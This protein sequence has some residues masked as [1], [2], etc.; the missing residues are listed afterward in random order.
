YGYVPEESVAII[1][2]TLYSIST[3]LHIGQA[4]YFRIWWLFPTAVACGVG[5]IIGWSGRLW[6][7]QNPYAYTPFL[8][9]ISTTV[10]APSL[11]LAATFIIMSRI[12]AQLGTS[13][14]WLTPKWCKC[15]D[16]IALVVQAVGGGI[17]SAATDLAGANKGAN[18]MLGGIAFQFEVI[19][20]FTIL[21]V[22][23]VQR[24]IRDRPVRKAGSR[25]G[26][27]FPHLKVM[28]AFSTTVLFIRAV[29]RLIELAG[30]WE[31]PVVTTQ[32]YF[33]VLD[34]AMATLAIFTLN[35]AH[36]GIFL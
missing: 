25:R 7:S 18:I 36:P 12:V 17:A 5:E 4:I 9:Q 22:D 33:N 30:G 16:C 26:V 14:S 15:W 21:A 35:F 20:I 2:V 23:F 34:G 11:L 3:I 1:F 24:Y 13:Y 8:I 27:L 31:G 19:I 32:V 10:L 29:Y 28:L 6:S